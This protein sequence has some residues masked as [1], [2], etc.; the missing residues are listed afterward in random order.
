MQFPL[1]DSVVTKT[2]CMTRLIV[3]SRWTMFPFF[4]HRGRDQDQSEAVQF[5]VL[6]CRERQH[7]AGDGGWR[8]STA[9][10]APVRS[11]CRFW[12]T[13]VAAWAM[14]PRSKDNSRGLGSH[15]NKASIIYHIRTP[16]GRRTVGAGVVGGWGSFASSSRPRNLVV[17]VWSVRGVDECFTISIRP[18]SNPG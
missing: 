6:G 13:V 8:A 11:G 4:R 17:D 2:Q 14:G 9:L 7:D 15:V 18:T 1:S 16:P 3:R 10:I 5:G 12:V